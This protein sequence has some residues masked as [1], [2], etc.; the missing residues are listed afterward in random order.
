L[1]QTPDGAWVVVQWNLA[2]IAR[3]GGD[4]PMWGISDTSLLA[5]GVSPKLDAVLAATAPTTVTA[6]S[7]AAAKATAILLPRLLLTLML[8]VRILPEVRVRTPS[9]P[10]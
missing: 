8:T 5:L 4:N 9:G 10:R 7:K 2:A 3:S 1:I 6:A